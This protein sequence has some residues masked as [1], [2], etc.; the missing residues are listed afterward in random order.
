MQLEF[1]KLY[2]PQ[3]LQIEEM[4]GQISTPGNPLDDIDD[5][6]DDDDM[7]DDRGNR[8]GSL[9]IEVFSSVKPHSGFLC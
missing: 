1:L 9:D 3:C 6:D 7:V 2:K 5:D 4:L 8:D